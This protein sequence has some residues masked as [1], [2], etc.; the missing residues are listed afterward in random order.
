[1]RAD[2]VPSAH[3]RVLGFRVVGDH[4]NERRLV[5]WTTALVAH[6]SCDPQAEV[7]SECYLSAFTFG[8]EFRDHLATN[9]TTK[10]YSGPC[11]ALW[12]WFDL[13]D[14]DD[15]GRV[16]SDARR[17]CAGLVDRYGIDGDDLLIFY[18]G[19]KG[20]HVGLPMALCGS[21]APS[22]LFHRVA[23]KFAEATA[24]RVRVAIDC[25][26]YDRV[27]LFRAPNSRHQKT[28]RYKRRVSFDELMG[29]RQDAIERT[30]AAPEPFDV[31]MAPAMDI[32]AVGDWNAATEAVSADDAAIAERRTTITGATLNRLT[33]DFIRDGATAGDR[34]R[35]LFSAAANLAEFGASFELVKALLNEP[36][37]DSGLTPSDVTR[38]IRCG[39]DG[40]TAAGGDQ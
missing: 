26:V 31:P 9:G 25:G 28:G 17:L 24:D 3:R 36:A 39:V 33:V 20:Y 38:Q 34:H 32:T 2:H 6:A 11:G 14:G 29:L 19:S 15:A 37:L 35:L 23:R 21:P 4:R 7:D 27:R 13:D 16:L 8:D 1:M 5:D 22:L 18:S 12:L 30:A 40:V 10:G